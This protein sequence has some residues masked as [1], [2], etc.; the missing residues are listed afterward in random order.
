MLQMGHNIYYH[1]IG[2]GKGP[3][4]CHRGR[5]CLP[6]NCWVRAPM[7]RKNPSWFGTFI[8]HLFYL[9][10]DQSSYSKQ[11]WP[12]W[13]WSYYQH[14]QK[15]C[16]L[17]EIYAQ[18]LQSVTIISKVV[19]KRNPTQRLYQ[20]YFLFSQSIHA[21]AVVSLNAEILASFFTTMACP[22]R[23]ADYPSVFYQVFDFRHL[24][25]RSLSTR[26]IFQLRNANSRSNL[27]FSLEDLNG[28]NGSTCIRKSCCHGW[29]FCQFL[30][31]NKEVIRWQHIKRGTLVW[32]FYWQRGRTYF[33]R[34]AVDPGRTRSLY[35]LVWFWANPQRSQTMF[36]QTTLFDDRL[37]AP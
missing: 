23:P 20:S 26:P 1:T 13:Q 29:R 3:F 7:A 32:R 27:I 28:K 31:C 30:V 22:E 36:L 25:I 33:Q 16:V 10:P 12:L 34:I 8:Y 19:M 2:L 18:R 35:C 9:R 24:R 14:H 17:L 37:Y 5:V 4:A 15:I 6:K 21:M 11:I